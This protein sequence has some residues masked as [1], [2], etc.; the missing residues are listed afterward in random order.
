[1]VKLYIYALPRSY[2][3]V[4]LTRWR[5]KTIAQRGPAPR[6]CIGPPPARAGPHHSVWFLAVKGFLSIDSCQSKFRLLRKI[7]NTHKLQYILTSSC[8]ITQR[9]RRCIANPIKMT[10]NKITFSI[11][12]KKKKLGIWARRKSSMRYKVCFCWFVSLLLRHKNNIFE[13]IKQSCSN[14]FCYFAYLLLRN[15]R[16]SW[17]GYT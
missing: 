11:I 5:Y 8:H 7:S 4:D 2:S 3:T 13:N 17:F 12:E 9:A 15:K 6:S 1:M 10:S 16:H 14:I